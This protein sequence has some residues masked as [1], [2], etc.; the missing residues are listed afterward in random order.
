MAATVALIGLG[1]MG[2]AMADRLIGA[3]FNTRVAN[4]GEARRATFLARGVPAFA[5]AAEAAIGAEIV[6]SMLSDDAALRSVALEPGGLVDAM[7]N[8]ALHIAMSTVSPNVTREVCAAHR[9]RG[10]DLVAAPV[11][12]R[13]DVA[14]SGSLWILA[15]GRVA[16]EARCQ[17]I[18]AALGRGHSWLGED[19]GLANVAKIM[20]NFLLLSTVEAVAEALTLAEANGLA[21]ERYFEIGKMLFPTPIYE[22][23]GGRMLRGAFQPAGFATAMAL[24]DAGLALGLAADASAPTPIASLVRD[25]LLSAVAHGRGDWDLSALIQVAR[26]SAGRT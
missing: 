13:P 15:A 7:A 19:P 2:A 10:A 17:P 5:R 9:A 16:H 3:G 24:K 6:I 26:E 14:A 8:G 11:M 23:Y 1:N 22:G 18:F 21:A 12:G 25:R 20:S 4:R